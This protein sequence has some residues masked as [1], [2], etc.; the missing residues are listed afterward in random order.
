ML[1]EKIR[2]FLNYFCGNIKK[3][4]ISNKINIIPCLNIIII[5]KNEDVL[6]FNK[7]IMNNKNL[8]YLDIDFNNY[9]SWKKNNKLEKSNYAIINI[10]TY[11]FINPYFELNILLDLYKNIGGIIYIS[12]NI[13]N[14]N[15]FMFSISH[16]IFWNIPNNNTNDITKDSEYLLKHCINGK[17]NENINDIYTTYDILVLNK[18]KLWPSFEYLILN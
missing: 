12:N 5:N 18:L 17:N 1:E 4:Y 9:W 7:N 10:D 2:Y 6:S 8:T 16:F 13:K 3:F 15:K 14:I 11:S